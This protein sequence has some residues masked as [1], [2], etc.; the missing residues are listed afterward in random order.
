MKYGSAM[1]RSE[2]NEYEPSANSDLTH[3]LSSLFQNPSLPFLSLSFFLLVFSKMIIDH[4][5]FH[6]PHHHYH[7]W[8]CCD[9]N[10]KRPRLSQ[11]SHLCPSVLHIIIIIWY[12]CKNGKLNSNMNLLFKQVKCELLNLKVT[13]VNKKT[14]IVLSFMWIKDMTSHKMYKL[15]I[16]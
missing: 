3:C 4:P 9:K 5:H 2:K 10:A 11:F 7:H 1:S 8:K 13:H 12:I 6:N 15:D 16:W 14:S